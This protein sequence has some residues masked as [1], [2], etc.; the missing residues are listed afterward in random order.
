MTHY[1]DIILVKILDAPTESKKVYVGGIGQMISN[2]R[3]GRRM[4]A[5][6]KGIYE[7]NRAIFPLEHLEEVDMADYPEMFI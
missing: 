6:N 3:D 5:F 1:E 4:V 7:Y 2:M